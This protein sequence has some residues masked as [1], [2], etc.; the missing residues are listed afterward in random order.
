[1]AS[2][3]HISS[4][5]FSE[6]R[7]HLLPLNLVLDLGYFDLHGV[8]LLVLDQRDGGG[9]AVLDGLEGQVC[10][11]DVPLAVVLLT[12]SVRRQRTLR[13]NS[14]IGT[15]PNAAAPPPLRGR[16]LTPPPVSSAWRRAAGR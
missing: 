14:G 8:D 1:M 10:Q 6:T 5:P 9:L 4:I 11:R 3:R 7:S 13:L 12:F 15:R 16:E 2:P